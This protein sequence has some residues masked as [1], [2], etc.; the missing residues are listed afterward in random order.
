MTNILAPGYL[1][2]DGSKYITSQN[3]QGPQGPVGPTGP[4]GPAGTITSGSY[5]LSSPLNLDGEVTI[6]YLHTRLG[7][8]SDGYVTINGTTTINAPTTV[9]A[10]LTVTSGNTLFA[11]NLEVGIAGSGSFII[12]AGVSASI[13]ANAFFYGSTFFN[14]NTS[15]GNITLSGVT[16]IT[17]SLH[18]TNTGGSTF[19]SD[20]V[21]DFGATV[22]IDGNTEF[23]G[24]NTFYNTTIY[25]SSSSI[26]MNGFLNAINSANYLRGTHVFNVGVL[27]GSSGSFDPL[28]DGNIFTCT[29]TNGTFI[30]KTII[31]SGTTEA[32]NWVLVRNTGSSIGPGTNLVYLRDALGNTLI[33]LSPEDATGNTATWALVVKM[34]PANNNWVVMMSGK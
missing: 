31:D 2:F 4:T 30:D 21:V 7:L 20:V 18:V 3:L 25:D 27:D 26:F 19:S 34:G 14:G 22:F 29:C 8:L 10:N 23:S 13:A 12:N 11:K 33:Q 28:I 9:N 17:N 6:K 1:Y 24:T 15:A 5:V 32:G 16:T